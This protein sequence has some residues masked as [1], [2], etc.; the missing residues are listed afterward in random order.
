MK[1]LICLA[2]WTMIWLPQNVQAQLSIA[3]YPFQSELSFSTHTERLLWGDLRLLT[4]TFWGNITTEPALMANVLQGQRANT[5]LGLG[6]NFNFF[7]AASGLPILNG[8]VLYLG[9]R[10]KPIQA[11]PQIQLIGELS[12][13]MNPQFDGGLLRTRLGVAYQFERRRDGDSPISE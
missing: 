11:L 13:Y 2:A 9:V 1:K 8:Y 5:Y 7:N 12:P 10:F 6:S 3:Y 4:N